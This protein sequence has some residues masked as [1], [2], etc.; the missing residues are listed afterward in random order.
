MHSSVSVVQLVTMIWFLAWTFA[1]VALHFRLVGKL[2]AMGVKVPW[3]KQS[4]WWVEETYVEY[5]S[6][7]GIDPW[8]AIR[9]ILV[10]V[11][12]AAPAFVVLIVTL[13]R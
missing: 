5:C 9:W 13:V 12:A 8:P 4:R 11:A 3:S 2:E 1:A 7:Q 6:V 10:C